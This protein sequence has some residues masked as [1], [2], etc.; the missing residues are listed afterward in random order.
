MKINIVE[1]LN[2]FV[3]LALIVVMLVVIAELSKSYDIEEQ[4]K[5]NGG[6]LKHELLL[7]IR[8]S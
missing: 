6:Y 4:A 5:Q 7:K 2:T 8:T 3:L 1:V